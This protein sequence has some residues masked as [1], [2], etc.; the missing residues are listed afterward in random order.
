MADQKDLEDLILK[1][2]HES[3]TI[4]N[5]V[6]FYDQKASKLGT[7]ADMMGVISSL[8]A[9]LFVVQSATGKSTQEWVLTPEAKT[10]VTKGSP[11]A[12]IFAAVPAEGI[13]QKAL[14]AQMGPMFKFGYN[15]CGKNRWLKLDKKTK[16]ITRL[17]DSITDT[18]IGELKTIADGKTL[19]AKQIKLLKKRKF[20]KLV[21]RKIFAVAKGPNF[22]LQRS[23]KL[24]ADLTPEM[25]RSGE[26]KQQTWKPYNW[27]AEGAGLQTG[28]LHPLM[29]FKAEVRNV[30]INMGFDEMPTNQYVENSFWNFDALFTPQ[31]H[32]ARDAHDT[33]F[34]TAPATTEKL[35]EG[36]AQRVQDAHE[37]GCKGS[38]G[39]RYEW[40]ESEAKKNI[41]RTHTTAVSTRMLYDLAQSPGGFKPVRRFSIDRVFRNET[42]D[43]T[44]LA[45][46]HQVEGFIADRNL[47]LGDLLG[48]IK[49]FFH[50]MG[51]DEVTFKPAYNPYTEPSMEI[52]VYSK[53]LDKT[54]EIGNSGIFRPEM[55]LPM[56]LP[57]DVVLIAWGLSLERPTMVKYGLKN[58][59]EL[60]GPN[61][62]LPIIQSNPIC[63]FNEKSRE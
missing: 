30:L 14:M 59:R 6:T 27:D 24:A 60:F 38:I 1:T 2:L 23:G 13:G 50:Q 29:K 21:T 44:H 10:Y 45:E 53:E 49:E 52:F 61:V 47:T 22:S 16:T 15:Y 62:K 48:T 34:L 32:P 28:A 19:P 26:W 37:K 3:T 54:I 31:Q 42:L 12:Q 55:L 35:P 18:V 58:I 4:D 51:I 33:F 40:K 8:H 20:L 36:Y 57:E 41:L 43:A 25:L 56:G 9:D 46:F 63:N 39:Y 5:S 7:V 11:E 17:V